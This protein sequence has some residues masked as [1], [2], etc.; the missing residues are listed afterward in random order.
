MQVDIKSYE[1]YGSKELE[2]TIINYYTNVFINSEE[3]KLIL[4]VEQK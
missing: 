3:V 2:P 1:M 4:K